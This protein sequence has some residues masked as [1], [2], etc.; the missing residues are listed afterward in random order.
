MSEMTKYEGGGVVSNSGASITSKEWWKDPK[1]KVTAFVIAAL[2]A[3]PIY[4]VG[5]YVVPWLKT[6]VWDTTALLAG[7]GVL[8]VL[9]IILTNKKFW[10]AIK[11]LGEFIGRYTLGLVIELNPF[12]ILELQI[13]EGRKDREK[14]R[15]QGDVVSA[16]KLELEQKIAEKQ[17]ML[18][19]AKSR[20]QLTE[21][22][23]K[24][25]NKNGDADQA[26]LLLAD[27]E[28]EGAKV[29]GCV[30]YINTLTPIAQD[31]GFLEQYCKKIY[32][33]SGIK[34]EK[35]KVD[36]ELGRDKYEAV[37]SGAGVARASWKALMGDD[38]LNQDAELALRT[39]QQRV[40]QSLA[41]MK[42][43]MEL[44]SDVIR[45]LEKENTARARKG[46]DIIKEMDNQGQGEYQAITQ[47][48]WGDDL[49]FTSQSGYAHLLMDDV[50]TSKPKAKEMEMR[51]N[52]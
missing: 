1:N 48:N 51:F 15:K 36:L 49:K 34:I 35:S 16:K 9:L 18:T 21:R 22:A 41:E 2:S 10:R 45:S 13:E 25:A 29:S 17:K 28:L 24:I 5:T 27:Y 39:I 44:T 19:D 4:L 50:T 32:K 43:S 38:T 11:Y 6:V 40:S 23:I 42:N 46:I 47:S 33:L 7:V 3:Y 12:N 14:V 20:A 37:M 30:D 52:K 8:A 31:L 26:E